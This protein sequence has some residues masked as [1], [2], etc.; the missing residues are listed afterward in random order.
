MHTI[1]YMLFYAGFIFNYDSASVW[2]TGNCCRL[3]EIAQKACHNCYKKQYA[4]SIS[5]V[6][7][8]V[9][10]IEIDFYDSKNILN[11][12]G[13]IPNHWFVRHEAK[14]ES[15]NNN[16]CRSLA[17][18]QGDLDSCLADV[19]RW[20]TRHPNHD[21][22]TIFLDKKQGW[23]RQHSPE[24]LDKLITKYFDQEAIYKPN[25]LKGSFTTLRDAASSGAWPRYT[26]VRGKVI[27][28]L[29]GGN[30]LHG[31]KTL[32]QYIS[33]RKDSALIFAAPI[34]KREKDILKHPKG[35]SKGNAPYVVFCNFSVKHSELTCITKSKKLIS[36]VFNVEETKEQ[37][38]AQ[39]NCTN[40]IAVFDF[41]N[42]VF[43][44]K[45]QQ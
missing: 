12:R 31:N 10:A 45:H 17:T 41:R 14:S 30:L 36:R 4:S 40:Y 34:I 1:Y 32:S 44:N 27:F 43:T 20:T 21:L 2:D 28:C 25:E 16:C 22:I 5:D 42:I 29:T 33:N 11:R 3:N 39:Q 19:A 37:Y 9:A 8:H 15:G 7:D 23:S 13:A 24:D 26:D 18:G 6:L 35:I 38:S